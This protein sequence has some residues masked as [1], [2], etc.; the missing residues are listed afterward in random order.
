[1]TDRMKSGGTVFHHTILKTRFPKN[2][3]ERRDG[4]WWRIPGDPDCMELRL[5]EA[6][7]RLRWLEETSQLPKP[8]NKQNNKEDQ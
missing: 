7:C 1:M 3:E 5:P 4:S 2:E 8:T 6:V